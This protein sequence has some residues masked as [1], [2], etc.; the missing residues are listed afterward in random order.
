MKYETGTNRKVELLED[1]ERYFDYERIGN[2]KFI[3]KDIYDA[4]LPGIENFFYKTIIIPV[5]CSKDDYEYLTQC[6]R[7]SA[8]CWNALVEQDKLFYEKN[9]RYMTRGEL[10]TFVKN[11]TP[12]HAVG[13]QHVF[14]KYY[15]CRDAMFRSI[16]SQHKDS[17]K[18]KL[19]YKE[20]QYFY[21]L[22]ALYI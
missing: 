18:A 20:K 5:K 21:L 2:S 14:H 7:W 13:N 4:P 3:I 9:K 1:F 10:Q 6:N 15:R 19:P 22:L 16:Q 8:E 17:V 11:I 12:L